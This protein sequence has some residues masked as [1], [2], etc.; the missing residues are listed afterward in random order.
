MTL[1]LRILGSLVCFVWGHFLS[2]ERF[3]V[4]EDMHMWALHKCFRCGYMFISHH[5]PTFE[6]PGVVLVIPKPEDLIRADAI[7]A[8]TL[9]EFYREKYLEE[10][11]AEVESKEATV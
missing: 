5:V 9:E 4:D 2:C 10:W 6:K 8:Q 1:L 11:A 3:L 7:K